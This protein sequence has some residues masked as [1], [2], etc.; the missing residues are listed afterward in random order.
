[1]ELGRNSPCPCGSGKKYKQCCL[2]KQ[3]TPE[4]MAID[5]LFMQ[6]QIAHSNGHI[7]EA[8]SLYTSILHRN[9]DHPEANHFQGLLHHQTG[10]TQLA[11][12]LIE[13]SLAMRPQNKP[14]L[15]NAGLIYQAA[16]DWKRAEAAYRG[17][18]RLAPKDAI[19]WQNLGGVLME[20][21]NIDEAEQA[22]RSAVALDDSN[23]EYAKNLGIALLKLGRPGD[24][25]EALLCFKKVI[26]AD[27]NDAEGHNNQGIAL[28]LLNRREEALAASRA[29]IRLDPHAWQPWLNLAQIHL[30]NDEVENALDVYQRGVELAA[31][32]DIF[33]LTLGHTLNLLGKFD[34]ALAFFQRAYE[35]NPKDI[36]ILSQFISH[37]KFKS[38]DD[39][40]L[41]NARAAVDASTGKGDALIDLCFVLGKIMDKLEQFEDAFAYY[42]RGN[43]LRSQTLQFDQGSHRQYIDS[44][45][46]QYDASTIETLR[47]FGNSSETPIYIVGMPRSGTT[48]TEQIIA[49]H[50]LVAGGG[51]RIFWSKIEK[52]WSAK[53]KPDQT[54][55]ESI[56]K[57]CLCDLSVVKAPGKQIRRVTDKMPDNFLRVGLIHA[58]FP[59]ARI[60][61]VRRHPIDNC[62]SIYFQHFRGDHPYAYDLDNLAFYRHEYERLMCHW[63]SVIP[64]NRFFEFNY[65]DLVA[66]QDGMSRKLIEFCDLEWDSAC[67]DFHENERAIKTASV[68]QVR[69]KIYTSSVER[70]RHYEAH[71]AP[72]MALQEIG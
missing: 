52:E 40:L 45:I 38:I 7:A 20:Q 26:A 25:E 67:L 53:G 56:A 19:A 27:P 62:L 12:P 37:Q 32:K 15:T 63:R 35:K 60:I 34:T 51:E 47:A 3:S 5:A 4:N 28:G 17:L 49:S 29:A 66:N 13:R 65:E 6:A 42:Q 31:D 14:F 23:P 57:A 8:Q 9:P 70:W 69:Q 72:L 59:N 36:G 55:I 30:R 16:G 22:Y 58:T 43:Q 48:L 61:H 50:P 39:P 24:A 33:N 11:L 21:G 44:L 68:W 64:A 54:T 10:R 2:G 71:I 1:M 46:K 18:T 41:L